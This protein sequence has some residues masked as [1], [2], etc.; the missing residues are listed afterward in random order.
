V[1]AG[2]LGTT[3]PFTLTTGLKQGCPLSP[4]LFGLYIDDFESHLLSHEDLDTFSLPSLMRKLVP[5]LLYADDLTLLSLTGAGLQAQLDVLERYPDK[6]GLTVNLIKTE[7]VVF[8]SK[9]VTPF[10]TYAGRLVPVTDSFIYLGVRFNANGSLSKPA[11]THRVTKGQASLFSMRGQAKALGVTAPFLLCDLFDAIVR[12]TMEYG[13]EIWGAE[14]LVS[15]KRAAGCVMK[16]LP[17]FP[18]APSGSTLRS[19]Y[20]LFTM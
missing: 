9:V 16:K 14:F 19:R 11:A 2:R 13:V 3:V 17:L 8:N 6:W 5:P 12:P 20:W 15:G 7:V 4:T 1:N 10:C 18:F